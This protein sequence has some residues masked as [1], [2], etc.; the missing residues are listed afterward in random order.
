M[1]QRSVVVLVLFGLVTGLGAGWRLG[2]RHATLRG[3]DVRRELLRAMERNQTLQDECFLNLQNQFTPG[4]KRGTI[5]AGLNEGL[6]ISMTQ[7]QL[8]T[9]GVRTYLAVQGRGFFVVSDSAG[10][11]HYTRD[12]RFDASLRLDGKRLMGYEGQRLVP[13]EAPP[14][15]CFDDQGVLYQESRTVDPVTGQE[16]TTRRP[17]GRI[18]VADFAA[19]EALSRTGA[20][21]FAPTDRSGP[22]RMDVPATL[23]PGCL[24]LS[25]VDWTEQ[26]YCTAA[27][28]QQAGL[29]GLQTAP[30]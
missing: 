14:N 22:P 15:A 19:P 5:L 28:R 25:N 2:Q 20:T 30:S 12:G 17:R 9:T 29:L 4:Y 21:T 18:A 10:T 23:R 13:L 6:A 3:A 11:L 24:E 16:V 8:M 1:T 26:A 7:G 27:L